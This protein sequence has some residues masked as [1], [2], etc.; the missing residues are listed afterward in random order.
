MAVHFLLG[1]S[2]SGKSTYLYRTVL[3]A[4]AA[5]PE[6]TFIF[7][8]PEQFTM[9][10]QKELVMRSPA[11]AIMNIEV[12][13]FRRFA[14]RIFDEL[15]VSDFSVLQDTGKSLLLR[16]TAGRCRSDLKVIGRFVEQP[17]CIAELKSLFSEFEQYRITPDDF[18]AM[19]G[20]FSSRRAFAAKG[21][22][23]SLLYHEFEKDLG[24][25]YITSEQILGL[26]CRVIQDSALA[27]G[28]SYFFD[29]F[30]GFTPVENELLSVLMPLSRDMYFT[31]DYDTSRPVFDFSQEPEEEDL[32]ALSQKM[33]HSLFRMAQ[34]THTTIEEPVRFPLEKNAGR[35]LPGGYLS[36][37][38][39]HL[40]CTA[41]KPYDPALAKEAGDEIR[42]IE[43]ADPRQELR[44][45][46]SAIHELVRTGGPDVYYS[47]FAVVAPNISDYAPFAEE[48]FSEYDFPVFVDSD[49]DAS[50]TPLPM[51]LYALFESC[52]NRM[53][54][55]DVIAMMRSGLMGFTTEEVDLFDHY[56]Y[57][58]GARG[59]RRFEQT[60][61][62][63]PYGFDGDSVA[64]AEDIRKRF[65]T[66]FGPFYHA[67]ADKEATVA[68]VTE[69]LRV[70]LDACGA[71]ER[72]LLQSEEFSRQG[73][74]IS[75]RVYGQIY[76]RITELFDKM[77][78]FIGEEKTSPQD[79]RDLLF[80]GLME[81]QIGILPPSNDCVV[82]G[83]MQRTRLEHIRC[84]FFLGADDDS[85]PQQ[86]GEGGLLSESERQMLSEHSFVLAPTER[87][88]AFMEHFYLYMVLTKASDRLFIT[89]PRMNMAGE[90]LRPS[91]LIGSVLSIFAG[92]VKTERG[93]DL[94]DREDAFLR[95]MV[96]EKSLR[97]SLSQNLRDLI[98]SDTM[99]SE[100]SAQTD[101]MMLWCAE[102]N[103]KLLQFLSEGALYHYEP[104]AVSKEVLDALHGSSI[105]G[106]ISRMESYNSCPYSYFLRYEVGLQEKKEHALEAA[107]SA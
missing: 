6:Q 97:R 8:V 63:C 98:F 99:D 31:A 61:S 41:D 43:F 7:L 23:L 55:E 9:S 96:T 17:G 95:E 28:A 35:F 27:A 90:R 47:Q 36:H 54:R 29:G 101:A 14:Y 102:H 16:R 84:L 75:A 25:T 71:E 60:F 81:V 49:T 57:S 73:D 34:E 82:F 88:R 94:F 103:P 104:A 74:E 105:N 2:G 45:A 59:I 53:M 79:Y 69:A 30:T 65:M 106:S 12:L 68:S 50:Y 92:T 22:D 77:N 107:L 33:L 15:G 62:V 44:F 86:S 91:Y 56:L 21:A 83:D 20:E 51:L 3:S 87:E 13:S 52:R 5:S 89:Y 76:Q 58:S 67:A 40:F 39:Q 85:L 72:L 64:R 26:L 4:A 48:I 32:F 1:P 66:L 11:H 24:D 18:D 78:A 80:S 70:F 38:E 42:V 37:L 10:A 93:G 19:I 46:A 100:T